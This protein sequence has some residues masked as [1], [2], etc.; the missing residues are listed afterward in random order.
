MPGALKS[1]EAA[2]SVVGWGIQHRKRA[3]SS[4][5]AVEDEG[6]ARSGSPP[7]P[8]RPDNAVLLRR[9]AR[10]IEEDRDVAEK[11]GRAVRVYGILGLPPRT[12]RREGLCGPPIDASDSQFPR[13]PVLCLLKRQSMPCSVP[14]MVGCPP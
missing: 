6:G 8:A 4:G 13:E 1:R 3:L 5:N 14:V 12:R 7:P 11:L 10:I 2:S 9:M